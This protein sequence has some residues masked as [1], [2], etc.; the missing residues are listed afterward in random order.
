VIVADHAP[1][2]H[3]P[4]ETTNPLNEISNGEQVVAAVK[5]YAALIPKLSVNRQYHKPPAEL[6]WRTIF[7][8]PQPS[9]PEIDQVS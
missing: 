1:A 9:V 3:E 2:P 6:H 5:G 4:P 7:T 8:H